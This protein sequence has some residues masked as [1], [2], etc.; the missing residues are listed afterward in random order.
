MKRTLLSAILTI[1]LAFA[2]N[3][4]IVNIPDANFKAYLLS[5]ATINSNSDTEIQVSEA[6]AFTGQINCPNLNIASLTG[7]EAFTGLTSLWCQGNNLTT[8]DLSANTSLIEVYCYVN[9]LTALNLSANTNLGWVDCSSNQLTS[10]DVSV[11]TSLNYL[12]CSYNQLSAL[13]VSANSNLTLLYCRDNQLTTLNVAN[14][15]NTNMGSS[16]FTSVNNPN[17]TCIEVDDAAYSTLNW[18]NV[19]GTSTFS[20]DC[21]SLS[22][23]DINA[24]NHFA[25]YPNPAKDIIN[26]SVQTNVQVFSAT[27]Q[28]ISENKNIS[29]LDISNLPAGIYILMLTDNKG[30]V[31]QRNKIVKE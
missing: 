6:S 16:S 8:I 29:I 19:G 21:A 25:V 27:G 12:S 13:D 1:T 14:G 17:L 5:N 3:A 15:N 30:Q 2:A 31:I 7:I 10:L 24:E 11:N 22:L 26:F 4:Q 18:T 23:N 9:S 28:L 20:E